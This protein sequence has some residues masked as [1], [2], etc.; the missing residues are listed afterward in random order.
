MRPFHMPVTR[1]I[2]KLPT[3]G[4]VTSTRPGG[5]DPT[6][7]VHML[8]ADVTATDTNATAL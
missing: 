8:T 7:D 2:D 6:G 4:I 5:C 3:L 1:P